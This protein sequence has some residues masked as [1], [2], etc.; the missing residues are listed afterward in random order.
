MLPSGLTSSQGGVWCCKTE[1]GGGFGEGFPETGVP[2]AG[3]SLGRGC[4][5][6]EHP[7]RRLRVPQP[8]GTE[9]NHQ[10]RIWA[11]ARAGTRTRPMSDE[12]VAYRRGKPVLMWGTRSLLG[13]TIHPVLD[14][15]VD[16]IAR[17][18]RPSREQ[19]DGRVSVPSERASRRR[20][21]GR[22]GRRARP[23]DG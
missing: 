5:S 13:C 7:P 17:E 6:L 8:S 20:E 3:T 9:S 4:R 19:A 23:R 22:P 14:G 12:G 10:E 11:D 1:K 15:S 2:P 18:T 16:P 21:G